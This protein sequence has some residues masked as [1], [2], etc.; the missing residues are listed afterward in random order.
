ME[1]ERL[2]NSSKTNAFIPKDNSNI[3]NKHKIF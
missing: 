2:M 1:M 3:I